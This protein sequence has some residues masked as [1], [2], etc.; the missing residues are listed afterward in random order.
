MTIPRKR[1]DRATRK[2]GAGMQS[3]IWIAIGGALGS[4][5]RFWCG[6]VS[7]RLVGEA[8]PWGT[9]FVNVLGSIVIGFFATIVGPDGRFVAS[10]VAKQF[11]IVGICGGF[12]TFSA[13]SLQTLDL[14]NKGEWLY[15]G[16]NIVA[17]VVLCLFAV[18]LGHVAA[19]GVNAM[20]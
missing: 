2:S 8:F 11:V 14:M 4:V 17:S 3:Y 7:A 16:A 20:K 10:T 13:F 5:A 1:G 15:A 18:W 12:T 9:L 6:I 19:T